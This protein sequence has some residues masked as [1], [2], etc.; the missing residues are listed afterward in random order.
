[1][2]ALIGQSFG[3]AL[4]KRGRQIKHEVFG[5]SS[6]MPANDDETVR[7]G[8]DERILA[9]LISENSDTPNETVLTAQLQLLRTD[10]SYLISKGVG[11]RF[12]EMPVNP[13]LVTLPRARLIRDAMHVAFHPG[14]FHY[15]DLPA[16]SAS[17]VTTD[18]IHLTQREADHYTCYFLERAAELGDD[19]VSAA[20]CRVQDTTLAKSAPPE[21]SDAPR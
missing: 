6:S 13:K 8:P 10:V 20:P 17:Y 16:D 7:M 21:S 4:R 11:I 19:P 12:F 2:L 5:I 3:I 14:R 1:P 15:I 18:G 9:G